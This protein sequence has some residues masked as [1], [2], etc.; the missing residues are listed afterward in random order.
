MFTFQHTEYLFGLL[1]LIPLALIFV[2]VLRWKQHTRKKLGDPS[3]IARL[4]QQYS[5]RLYLVKFIAVLLAVALSIVALANL[6]KPVSTGKEK[7][8]GIDLMIALDVSKSMWAEDA[9][10]TR[11]DKAKQF[12]NELIDQA[13][14]NRIGLVLFA[15]RAYLQMPLTT[16]AVAAKIF[17]SNASPDAVPV[18]GTE[19]GEALTLCNNSLDTKEKKYKAIVLISDGEDHDP[20]SEEVL[21]QLSD[22][23][24]II[25][26]VGVGSPAGS[27]ILEP[28][29]Q[30]YKK[31][32]NG[33][34]VISRLN[35]KELQD[36]AAKT[37]GEYHHL[38]DVAQ[39]VTAVT[40]QLNSMEKKEIDS[41]GGEKQYASF[42][43][44][45]LL[46]AVL[47][48]AAEIFIPERKKKLAV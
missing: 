10:P 42:Y 36:I 34:T 2:L 11:L 14:D 41:S 1:A 43:M 39:T 6:R 5:S 23:G 17:V 4:T 13:G 47:L 30:D 35:E 40:N 7:K 16:D 27:P 19:I 9:K 18:Q 15:G 32:V 28:G 37:S 25:N 31:D 46:P 45:F 21:Q 22:E 26:T 33:Q 8:G 38:D 24:V 29:S 44:L 3:L 20:K 48:L 12:I